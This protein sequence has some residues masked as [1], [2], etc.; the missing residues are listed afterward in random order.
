MENNRSLPIPPSSSEPL[1]QNE[2]RLVE[3]PITD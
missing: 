2:V 1:P 3:V